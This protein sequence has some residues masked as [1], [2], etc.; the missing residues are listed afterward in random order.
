MSAYRPYRPLGLRLFNAAGGALR[1]AGLPL[2]RLDKRSLLD[3]AA[4]NT[5]LSDF[6][7]ERFREPLRILLDAFEHE[8]ALTMLGRVIARSDAVRTLENRLRM[9]DTHKRHPEIGE[10]PIERPLF[11]LGLPR[12]GTTILHELLAQDPAT[13][14]PM[15]WEVM[16]PWPPP[17]RATYETDL[18]IAQVEKHFSGV[19]KLI[20]GFKSMHPM[21]A[22]LP[23]ECAALTQHDFATMIYHT[24]HNVPSYQRWLEQTDMRPVYTSHRRQL[25]YLQWRCPAERWVLKSPAHLWALDALLAIYPDARIVQ[26]HRDPLKVIASLASLV[27]LLRGMSSDRIDPVAIGADWTARLATGLQKTMTVRDS[28]ALPDDRVFD[29]QF[30]EFIADEIAMV[31]RI[32]QHF[33][34]PFTEAAETRMRRFLVANPKDKHGAHRYTIADAGLDPTAERQRYA[35]YQSR[36]AIKSEPLN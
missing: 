24:T 5:G 9:I 26:T 23:Q 31:R 36:H 28:G 34:L 2:V 17:E 35:A 21:G 6:G 13:R 25:Q 12:T 33:D 27:K 11:I 22:Q 10:R 16:H 3:Q 20:P 18:R 8:A 29:M 4:R 32:Y 30:A 19:D 14:V 7:D 1:A 15:T